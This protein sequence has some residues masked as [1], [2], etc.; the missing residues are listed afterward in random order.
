MDDMKFK[1]EVVQRL[2]KIE[3]MLCERPPC[4]Q[5]IIL[6]KILNDRKAIAVLFTLNLGLG[7]L[8][9]ALIMKFIFGA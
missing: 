6:D 8:F 9:V 5:K 1:I 7:S 4:K 2:T 3:T